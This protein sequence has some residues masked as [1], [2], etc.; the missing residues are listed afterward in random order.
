M[1]PGSILASRRLDTR[2]G[3]TFSRSWL[4]DS[5]SA[6][7]NPV[8]SLR[9]WHSARASLTRA[10]AARELAPLRRLNRL[11]PPKF[12][13]GRQRL[14]ERPSDD[15]RVL[16]TILFTDVVDSTGQLAQLGDHQ[17]LDVLRAHDVGARAELA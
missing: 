12:D 6:L 5:S 13:A 15:V 14:T 9:S 17:W 11:R 2:I 1:M 8:A 10:A 16:A 4:T 7:T 3:R